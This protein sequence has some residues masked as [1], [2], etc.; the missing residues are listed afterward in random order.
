M[1]GGT[2]TLCADSGAGTAGDSTMTVKHS[3]RYPLNPARL[4]DTVKP[5]DSQTLCSFRRGVRTRA[6]LKLS[7]L[8]SL[9]PQ[10]NICF[11]LNRHSRHSLHFRAQAMQ[12]RLQQESTAG[13]KGKKKRQEERKITPPPPGFKRS[14]RVR[15]Y[16]PRSRI[17]KAQAELE[18]VSAQLHTSPR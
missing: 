10:R 15:P 6:V 7:I 9:P 11:G 3:P 13:G 2:A 4:G 1:T 18:G 5:Q 17:S 14:L 12:L 8:L 16:T